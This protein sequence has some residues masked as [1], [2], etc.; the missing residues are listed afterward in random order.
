MAS[1][2]MLVFGDGES[3]R[4]ATFAFVI[5]REFDKCP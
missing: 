1:D 2:A 3:L 5:S 4:D